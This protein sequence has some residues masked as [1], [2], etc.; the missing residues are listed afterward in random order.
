VAR[1]APNVAYEVFVADHRPVARPEKE[2]LPPTASELVAPAD[3][4]D[5][6]LLADHMRS[7]YGS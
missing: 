4:W 7:N 5:R 6:L 1:R 3:D 2:T